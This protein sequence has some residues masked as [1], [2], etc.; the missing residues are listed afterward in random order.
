MEEAVYGR[1][2]DHA[3]IGDKNHTAEQSIKR[4]E[5]FSGDGVDIHYRTHAAQDHGGIM[6]GIQPG[7]TRCIMIPKNTQ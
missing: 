6:K 3:N 7:Y 4:R 2:E 1:R 5:Q